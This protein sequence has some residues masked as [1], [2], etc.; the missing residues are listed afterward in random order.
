MS[1]HFD[2][3]I[4]R[5]YDIRGIVGQTLSAADAR[6]VGRAYAVTLAEAGGRRVAVGYDGRLTSPELEAALVDG[7]GMEGADVV[8]IG[9][10]PT[11]MLYYAAATLGVDA[12]VMVTGSHNPPDQNGFKLV[13]QKRSFYGADIQ[14]IGEIAAA[15]RFR[16]GAGK[17]STVELL[18]EYVARLTKDYD[19]KRP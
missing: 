17:V 10:G 2:P 13:L 15:A 12:G 7:L 4:L 5:E 19:G 8:R 9:R 6:A 1:H 11:P 18:D 14:R 3:T 16:T